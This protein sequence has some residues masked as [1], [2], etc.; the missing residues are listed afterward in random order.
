MNKKQLICMWCGI[1]V[2]VGFGYLTQRVEHFAYWGYKG[3][4]FRVFLVA[5]ITGG[6]IV[7]FKDKKQD[8]E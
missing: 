1:G 5:L 4:F 6:L 3:F 7:T 2:I 8:G